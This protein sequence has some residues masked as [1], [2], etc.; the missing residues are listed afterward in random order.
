MNY[1]WFYSAYNFGILRQFFIFSILIFTY[2]FCCFGYIFFLRGD[3][4]INDLAI[5]DYNGWHVKN[6]L[7]RLS[8]YSRLDSFYLY[9]A[10]LYHFRLSITV[11][12]TLSSG[13]APILAQVYLILHPFFYLHPN[14]SVIGLVLF[15]CFPW[16]LN[17]N[18][19]D[20]SFTAI[21]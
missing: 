15:N 18:I 5:T 8:R 14:L 3:K 19:Y 20:L 7:C 16:H 21:H 6:L 17:T 1:F 11:D 4:R 13:F 10:Y 2:N 12:L 9:S